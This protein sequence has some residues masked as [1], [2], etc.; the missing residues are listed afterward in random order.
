MQILP[1]GS[2][3][4]ALHCSQ[5]NTEDNSLNASNNTYDNTKK[6]KQNTCTIRNHYNLCSLRDSI[7]FIHKCEHAQAEIHIAKQRK[8]IKN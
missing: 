4:S 5:S 3:F 1:Y 7:F 2:G 8:W 6:H